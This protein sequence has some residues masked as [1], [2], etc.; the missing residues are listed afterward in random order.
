[1]AATPPGATAQ[2]DFLT[3]EQGW[4]VDVVLSTGLVLSSD[5]PVFVRGDV[6]LMHPYVPSGAYL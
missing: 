5:G 2:I 3:A 4:A 1:L 6:G